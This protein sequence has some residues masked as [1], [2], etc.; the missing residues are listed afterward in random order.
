[1]QASIAYCL[2]EA[3][4]AGELPEGFECEEVAA[5][6]VSSLQGANLLAKAQRSPLPV[7]RFKRILFSRILR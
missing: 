2:A 3:V 1:V 7:R 6:V 4:K 5:F